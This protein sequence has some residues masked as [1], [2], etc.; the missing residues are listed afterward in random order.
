VLALLRAGES[1]GDPETWYIAECDWG[2]GRTVF[3]VRERSGGC[4]PLVCMFRPTDHDG[5]RQ[6]AEA[7]IEAAA[8]GVALAKDVLARRAEGS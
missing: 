3:E 4:T 6:D 7:C 1:F 2:D 8:Q 5:T